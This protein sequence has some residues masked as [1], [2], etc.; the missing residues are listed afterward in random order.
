MS[1]LLKEG[2]GF[3]S[4][5]LG[6]EVLSAIRVPYHGGRG[7]Y[8]EVF[9]A[10]C[11]NRCSVVVDHIDVY[12]AYPYDVVWRRTCGPFSTHTHVT[13]SKIFYVKYLCL[14]VFVVK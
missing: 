7:S 11:S 1:K 10:A 14:Y 13:H 2:F 12:R 9:P 5:D 4:S 3:V 8:V 6:R